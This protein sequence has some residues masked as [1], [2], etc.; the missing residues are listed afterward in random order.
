M[1]YGLS[2]LVFRKNFPLCGFLLA[3]WPIIGQPI[4]ESHWHLFFL[5]LSNVSHG[6]LLNSQLFRM[7]SA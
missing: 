2:L 3:S 5:K 6:T 4:D 1:Q 7:L